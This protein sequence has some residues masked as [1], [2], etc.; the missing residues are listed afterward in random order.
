M[1]HGIV[2]T[3]GHIALLPFHIHRN[4]FTNLL[5]VQQNESLLSNVT[6]INALLR[7][8]IYQRVGAATL[9]ARMIKLQFVGGHCNGSIEETLTVIPVLDGN[10]SRR[11]SI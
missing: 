10:Q 11:D 4:I 1:H 6:L 5:G 7:R 9:L 2:A 8:K 3:Q